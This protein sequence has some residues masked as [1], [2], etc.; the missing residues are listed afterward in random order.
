MG[1]TE[2]DQSLAVLEGV[3]TGHR[4]RVS[5]EPWVT[6]NA[7]FFTLGSF[8]QPLK[9]SFASWVRLSGRETSLSLAHWAK[10][11]ASMRSTPW[12]I[13]AL[14]RPALKKAFSP[15]AVTGCPSM[16][17]GMVRSVSEPV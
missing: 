2:R 1:E 12:E 5:S 16:E 13:F 10:A 4:I 15:M 9:A 11:L 3:N 14:V 7:T 17:A 8:L 6:F